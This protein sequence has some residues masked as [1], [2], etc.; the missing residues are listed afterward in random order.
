M[1]K[2]RY[3]KKSDIKQEEKRINKINTEKY[4]I[5]EKKLDPTIRW[6]WGFDQVKITLTIT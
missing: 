3:F 6:K 2:C 4:H 5:E 1:K